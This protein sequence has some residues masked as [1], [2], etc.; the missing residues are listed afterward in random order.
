MG[1]HNAGTEKNIAWKKKVPTHFFC[2]F[3]KKKKEDFKTKVLDR[4]VTD[5]IE[6]YLIIIKI[7]AFMNFLFFFWPMINEGFN[8]FE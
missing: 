6:T 8:H 7:S 5:Y 3:I 1:V 4:S 2:I